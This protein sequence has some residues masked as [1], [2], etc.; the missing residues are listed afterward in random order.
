[1]ELSS[2]MITTYPS[3]DEEGRVRPLR[4]ILCKHVTMTALTPVTSIRRMEP[5]DSN[6]PCDFRITY[7]TAHLGSRELFFSVDTEQSAVKWRKS[8]EAALFRQARHRWRENMS[9]KRRVDEEID[10]D[11]WTTMRICLPL[12]RVT[13]DGLSDY[14]GFVTLVGLDIVLDGE[15]VAWRPED[16][17]AGDYSGR[18]A[19]VA[20]KPAH[21]H[22]LLPF[23]R[24]SSGDRHSPDRAASM[25]RS[26]SGTGGHASDHEELRSPTKQPTQYIDTV[27]PPAMTTASGVTVPANN[28]CGSPKSNSYNF[29]V[30]VL[31]EQAWFAEALQAAVAAAQERKYRVGTVRP[32]MKLEIAGHDGLASDDE[33]DTN[34]E[35][36]S[37]S[38]EGVEEHGH[39]LTKDMR[40]AEKAIMA[41]KVFGLKE[42]ESIYRECADRQL[43]IPV[44]RCYVVGGLV[45]ARGHIIVTRKYIC[46]WRRATVG[47]DI[48]VSRYAIWV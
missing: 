26:S 20:P 29:K 21:R 44:K 18:T 43:L 38:S 24:S 8:L 3:G 7:E 12:D 16:A 5:F 23:H 28:F 17:A 4:T 13:I 36:D 31:N 1:M 30:A 41:A 39:R 14:H 11:G 46:F 33:V 42:D 47:E 22:S 34:Q 25:K 27:L 48:K 2:E 32:K 45:P 40:K 35:R 19:E 9:K 6:S 15:R 10:A 37:T